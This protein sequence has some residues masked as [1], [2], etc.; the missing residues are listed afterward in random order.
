MKWRS[1]PKGWLGRPV[2]RHGRFTLPVLVVAPILGA[3]LFLAAMPALAD[4]G[5]H[6][7]GVNSGMSTLSA[8]SCGGCHRAHT[9][10][11]PMLLTEASEEELCFSCHGATAGGAT[12]DVVDGVQYRTTGRGTTPLLGAL[13]NGGFV[14]SAIDTGNAAR[15]LTGSG[16]GNSL[17]TSRDALGKVR[18]LDGAGV[19]VTQPVTSAHLNLPENGMDGPGIAWGNP[20]IGT[21]NLGP[22]PAVM[23]GCTSCHNPHG[24][25]NYR[26]LVPVPDFPG[27]GFDPVPTQVVTTPISVYDVPVVN[28][29][30][31]ESST[32]N[33]TV[34]QVKGTGGTA[35][36]NP[37]PSSLM[38]YADDVID[39]GYG[40]TQGDY[41]HSRV[42][43]N[44]SAGAPDAPNGRQVNQGGIQSFN[45]QMTM[46][47][48][49]CH[50]RYYSTD[51]GEASGDDL[52]SFRHVTTSN[53]ACTTCHVGHGSN[54]MMLGPASGL[55]PFPNGDVRTYTVDGQLTGDSRLLKVDGRGTCQL[56]HD[57]TETAYPSQP[58]TGPVPSP[59][60]P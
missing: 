28:P 26:I 32:K 31:A 45:T 47:C 19:V 20:D 36:T 21:G 55:Q 53:R 8:D 33:Y 58:Y 16:Y 50:T 49:S 37:T 1:S 39:A 10:Q 6:I 12:T 56:C 52:F 59:G 4:G 29:D 34:I 14:R 38:L 46:W 23:M 15:I 40:P 57:P 48:S 60:V 35:T 51:G 27:T 11:G 3:W 5:P 25:G 13:R 24:N 7:S 43:W 42:P 18:V 2:L 22:G 54:A 30:P 41:W 17:S 9:A 44:S